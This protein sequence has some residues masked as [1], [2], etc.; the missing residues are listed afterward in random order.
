MPF[1]HGEDGGYAITVTNMYASRILFGEMIIELSDAAK[2]ATCFLELRNNRWAPRIR[3]VIL[4]PTQHFLFI[5]VILYV[6]ASGG[7]PGG[8]R[9]CTS[10]DMV[11]P[12]A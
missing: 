6:Q 3:C 10:V 5:L 8:H 11:W 12:S 2:H 1:G 9:C 4:P 7:P